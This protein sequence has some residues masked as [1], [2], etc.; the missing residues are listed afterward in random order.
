MIEFTISFRYNNKEQK[1]GVMKSE[2]GEVTKYAVRP[3]DPAIVQQFGKQV[4]IFKENENYNSNTHID[5]EYT[6][7]F[8]ALV[9]ALRVQDIAEYEE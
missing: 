1:A 4:I 9:D 6:D 3:I 8:N 7:F 2:N 5:E